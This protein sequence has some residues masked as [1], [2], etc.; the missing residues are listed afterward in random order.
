MSSQVAA[1][2]RNICGVMIESNING[3]SQKIT[4]DLSQLQYGVSVTDACVAWEDTVPILRMLAEATR[5]RRSN[6]TPTFYRS[7]I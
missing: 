7:K 6:E 1:G 5:Q 4:S 2:N 3:G